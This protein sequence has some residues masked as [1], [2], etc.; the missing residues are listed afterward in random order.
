MKPVAL[1]AELYQK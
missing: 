1:L